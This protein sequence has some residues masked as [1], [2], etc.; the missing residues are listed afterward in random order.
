MHRRPGNGCQ[1]DCDPQITAPGLLNTSGQLFGGGCCADSELENAGLAG[2]QT[3][4][5]SKVQCFM[6]LETVVDELQLVDWLPE[7][8]KGLRK[9]RRPLT[10]AVLVR[11][12]SGE[13]GF[14]FSLK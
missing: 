2:T 1:E 10:S 7:K 13:V 4:V 12:T 11:R 3:A 8:L 9:A 14:K 6:T 5:N